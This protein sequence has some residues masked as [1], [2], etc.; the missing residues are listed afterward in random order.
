MCILQF[1]PPISRRK[2]QIDASILDGARC[3]KTFA[4]L[5]AHDAAS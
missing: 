1:L 3:C 5:I 4:W 2:L